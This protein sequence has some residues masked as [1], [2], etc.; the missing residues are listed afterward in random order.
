MPSTDEL[1]STETWVHAHPQILKAN[2]VSHYEPTDMDDE[3]KEEYMTK[4]NDTDPVAERFKALN[5]DVPVKGL[6]MAWT[7]KLAGDAQTYNQVGKEGTATYAVNVL[8][9]IRW[10]GACTVS[11]GGK[12]A[13][14]YVGYGMKNGD[15]NF[16]PT[17]P[18]EIQKDPVDQKE[19]PEP[20]PLT[21]PVVKQPDDGANEE[22]AEGGEN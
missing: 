12:F 8:K 9:S 21:E 1:K 2:R 3:A 11:Q 6:E 16:N 18:P 7:S 19:Q 14:I 22:G 17:E 13:S 15:V 20:T 4:L 5:E 10:P